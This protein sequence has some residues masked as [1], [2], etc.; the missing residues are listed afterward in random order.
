VDVMNDLLKAMI[1]ITG[2]ALILFAMEM[3]RP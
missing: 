1:V 2:A 3:M